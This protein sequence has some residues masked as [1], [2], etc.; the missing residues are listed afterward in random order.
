ML[1]AMLSTCEGLGCDRRLDDENLMLAM[2]T[3]G[4]ERRAYECECGTVTITVVKSRQ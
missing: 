2:E 4:G 1:E 3:A